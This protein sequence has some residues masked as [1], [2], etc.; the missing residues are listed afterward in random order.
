M[1][2]RILYIGEDENRIQVYD[3]FSL[4]QIITGCFEDGRRL[5]L[6]V[7]ASTIVAAAVVVVY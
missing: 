2:I 7:L 6:L 5:L 4:Q 3:L 1:S